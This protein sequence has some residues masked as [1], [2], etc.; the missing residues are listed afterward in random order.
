LTAMRTLITSLPHSEIYRVIDA[1]ED[2]VSIQESELKELH[3]VTWEMVFEMHR[4]GMTIGSHTK[5]H[6]LLPNE[7]WEKMLDETVISRR[8]L[9][10]K[11]GT[12]IRHFAYPDGKFNAATVSLIADAGYRFAYTTC[13]HRDPHYPLLTI[14]RKL[15]WENTCLNALG[16]F[17]PNIMSCNV[18]GI[19]DFVAGCKQDHGSS[20]SMMMS[21]LPREI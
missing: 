1:L 5:N 3:P 11:L 20:V 12:P 7:R 14:P 17:S 6:V 16:R 13:S 2:Q 19:F 15:L 18:N 9:E 10:G 21:Q 8:L 4:A